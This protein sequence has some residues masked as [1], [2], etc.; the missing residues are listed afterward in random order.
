MYIHNKMNI[1][2]EIDD[3]TIFALV[4]QA[5]REKCSI[6]EV[7]NSRLYASVTTLASLSDEEI[8]LQLKK[9]FDSAII[10]FAGTNLPFSL[11]QLVIHAAGSNV[12]SRYSPATRKQ[13][14]KRFK[15]M[16]SENN[17]VD[18]CRIVMTGKTIT[19]T[20]LYKVVDA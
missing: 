13:F 1:T 9:W 8:Q 12:W 4:E 2:I 17:D 16:I 7:I 6:E 10:D 15:M 20:A 5:R 3:E 11:Q 19:N 14:G 18:G